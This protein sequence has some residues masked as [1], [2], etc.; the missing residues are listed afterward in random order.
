[1]VFSGISAHFISEQRS[2]DRCTA[3][4]TLRH[5]LLVASVATSSTLSGIG[6]Q[7]LW[8]PTPDLQLHSILAQRF[9]NYR[10]GNALLFSQ[11]QV[12]LV[13]ANFYRGHQSTQFCLPIIF[14]NLS[15]SFAGTGLGVS[16]RRLDANF[17]NTR[18]HF[19]GLV[20]AFFIRCLLYTSPS[21]RDQRGARMPSSA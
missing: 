19:I 1:M 10:A 6:F 13:L 17:E 21:P 7:S 3:R 16:W 4:R 15:Y 9:R 5:K 20:V 2:P 14:G 8:S 18:L 11:L 12:V